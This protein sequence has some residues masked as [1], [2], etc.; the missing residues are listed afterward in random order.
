M[1]LYM[2]LDEN[3]NRIEQT[4]TGTKEKLKKIFDK[5][6]KARVK[7]DL[8]TMGDSK[9]YEVRQGKNKGKFAIKMPKENT[10]SFYET[11]DLAEKHKK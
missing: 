8:P 4:F 1:R 10:Y 11:E 5:N 3:G 7:G 2:G 9:V 6:N